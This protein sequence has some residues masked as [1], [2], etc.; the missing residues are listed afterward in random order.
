MRR[1]TKKAA[2]SPDP[3]LLLASAPVQA[4]TPANVAK[5]AYPVE[6]SVKSRRRVSHRRL[7]GALL[8]SLVFHLSMVTVF[9]IVVYFPREELAYREFHIVQAPPSAP[10]V[11]T[12]SET[13]GRLVLAGLPEIQLPT[14]EFAELARLR[15]RQE[16]LDASTRYDALIAEEEPQDSWKQ[17]IT[18]MQDLPKTLSRLS[19]SGSEEVAPP[20]PA[21]EE[22][23][24]SPATGFAG[25]VEWG[26]A[27]KDRQLLF[28]AP[29]QALWEAGPDAFKRPM[30]LVIEVNPAGRVVSVWNPAAEEDALA[31]RVQAAMLK[32]RFALRDG[33]DN[34]LA[35]VR[36]RPEDAKS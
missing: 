35:T 9:R 29:I 30:E 3:D 16:S 33:T 27:P 24:F 17:F 10:S 28:A 5:A 1:R 19:L 26:A 32:Y 20:A 22:V 4:P 21:A 8:F 34:Q 2:Y 12:P 23:A 13:P 7:V 31:D 15:E 18:G 11:Q 14:L 25:T 36:I 6:I